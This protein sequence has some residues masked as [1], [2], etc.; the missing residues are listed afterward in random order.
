MKRNRSFVLRGAAVAT[1]CGVLLLS[2]GCTPPQSPTAPP[3]A[4]VASEGSTPDELPEPENL[5]DFMWQMVL[6]YEPDAERPE[7][8]LI[9]VVNL[10]EIAEVQAACI[11]EA[12]FEVKVWPD[13]TFSSSPGHESQMGAFWKMRYSCLSQYPLDSKYDRP[14]DDAQ[15]RALYDYQR[16]TLVECLSN[17]G[18]DVQAAPSWETYLESRLTPDFWS[19]YRDVTG[20]GSHRL[21]EIKAACPETPEYIYDMAG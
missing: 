8:P 20:V 21:F 4:P 14:F 1:V 13:G 6:Q 10:A 16:T 17:Q 3:T 18:F 11:R 9:R 19:P 7:V 15:V 2:A 5:L 12:G